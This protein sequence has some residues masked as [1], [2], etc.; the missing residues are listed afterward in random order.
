MEEGLL[1]IKSVNTSVNASA[2]EYELVTVTH[3]WA[4]A[5]ALKMTSLSAQNE[6]FPAI[7]DMVYN[8]WD[9]REGTTVV[10]RY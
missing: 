7:T 8:R 9:L 10:M 4:V 6:V 1:E 2:T 3:K 5:W